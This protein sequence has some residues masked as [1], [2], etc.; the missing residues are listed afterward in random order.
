LAN[1]VLTGDT[2]GRL[3]TAGVF[4]NEFPIPQGG[5][6]EPYGI[7]SGP[8]GALWFTEFAGFRIGRVSTSGVFTEYLLPGISFNGSSYTGPTSDDP[9]GITSGPDGALWFTEAGTTANFGVTR[10]DG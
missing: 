3:T 1:W 10:L 7:V 5:G 8:D 6:P 4:T 2:I 9:L